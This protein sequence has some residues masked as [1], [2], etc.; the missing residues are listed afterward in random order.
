MPRDVMFNICQLKTGE[1]FYE[2]MPSLLDTKVPVEDE[3]Q[4]SVFVDKL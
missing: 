3:E 4:T 1:P 2:L